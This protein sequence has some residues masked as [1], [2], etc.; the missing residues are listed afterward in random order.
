MGIYIYIYV[1]VYD[2]RFGTFARKFSKFLPAVY[3][4]EKLLSMLLWW[5]INGAWL[6]YYLVYFELLDFSPKCKMVIY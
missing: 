5:Y 6:F 1:Q 2:F 4:L 3:E